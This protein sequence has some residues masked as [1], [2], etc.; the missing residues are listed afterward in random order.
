MLIS[1]VERERESGCEQPRRVCPGNLP[2]EK[3]RY[4]M[5]SSNEIVTDNWSQAELRWMSLT[6]KTDKPS[7]HAYRDAV[8]A[9]DALFEIMMS[10]DGIGICGGRDGWNK[11]C[12]AR[13]AMREECTRRL[14]VW[15]SETT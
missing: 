6:P 1:C 15:I 10:E 14:N 4:L 12:A 8:V 11:L 3:T 5:S 7:F 13:D 9:C 2:V